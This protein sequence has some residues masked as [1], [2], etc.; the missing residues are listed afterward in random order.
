MHNI[1]REILNEDN[2]AFVKDLFP[3]STEMVDYAIETVD[4]LYCKFL[5]RAAD[6]ECVK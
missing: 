6:A 5:D 3:N 4:I 1:G 2:G